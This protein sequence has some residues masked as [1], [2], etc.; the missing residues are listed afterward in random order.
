M[1]SLIHDESKKSYSA[2]IYSIADNKFSVKSV[3]EIG[4]NDFDFEQS[5]PMNCDDLLVEFRQTQNYQLAESP[6]P[7]Q[8][9]SK[10]KR[11]SVPL[12]LEALAEEHNKRRTSNGTINLLF[13]YIIF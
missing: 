8:R 12:E 9:S 4:S 1:V 13:T 10:G 2:A 5:L 7:E 6:V 11:K 3:F